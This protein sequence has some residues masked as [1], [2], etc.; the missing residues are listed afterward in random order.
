MRSA[1]SPYPNNI[2]KVTQYGIQRFTNVAKPL[3]VFSGT[4]MPIHRVI[5][6]EYLESFYYIKYW[7]VKKLDIIV[8]SEQLATLGNIIL[9][10]ELNWKTDE[11]M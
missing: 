11:V 10:E 6:V 8:T 9:R 2:D 3:S 1:C 7:V 5:R 4:V